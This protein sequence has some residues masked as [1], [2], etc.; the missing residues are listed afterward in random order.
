MSRSD[1]QQNGSASDDISQSHELVQPSLWEPTSLEIYLL[2][3][4]K[5]VD[6]PL[7]SSHEYR[8]VSKYSTY[9][10]EDSSNVNGSQSRSDSSLVVLEEHILL[11]LTL[12]IYSSLSGPPSSTV[13][14][15]EGR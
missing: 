2:G 6:S 4:L 1:K 5:S 12:P 11:E 7:R 13:N 8:R 3:L 15:G 14:A 10:R 9:G